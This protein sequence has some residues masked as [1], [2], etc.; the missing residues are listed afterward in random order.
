MELNKVGSPL[1][2]LLGAAVAG[3]SLQTGMAFEQRLISADRNIR[4]EDAAD[5]P[6]RS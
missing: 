2:T 1:A 6:H 4:I 5:Q 3:K